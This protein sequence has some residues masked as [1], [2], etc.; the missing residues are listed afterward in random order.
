MNTDALTF[1]R[2]RG[3][4]TADEWL[5]LISIGSSATYLLTKS[6][7]PFPGSILLKAMSIAPLAVLAV[8][9]LRGATSRQQ[10]MAWLPVGDN[11][12]LGAALAA[13]CMGD[14][15][16]DLPGQHFIQGLAAFLVAHLIYILLFARN[17]PRPLRPKGW[18]LALAV[19]I[20]IYSLVLSNWLA[21]A[22]GELARP[23]AVYICAITLMA[24]FAVFAGFARPWVW[25]GAVLFLISD[26]MIAAGRFKTPVPF[27]K[28]LVWATYYL[29]QY[30][31]AI[32]FLR[33]KQGDDSR[34]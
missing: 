13:S 29:A 1:G 24:V 3:F 15:F 10:R 5:L 32:G 31:I 12:I 22:L 8:R 16:L 34:Q 14:V 11:L 26:S 4:R 27:D 33:E 23:V 6:L 19:L 28:Y 17:W 20:L 30:G 21:P 2:L 18:Q 9:A 7:Q 25:I